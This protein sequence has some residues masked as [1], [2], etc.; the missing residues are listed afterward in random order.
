MGWEEYKEPFEENRK[1]E[2]QLWCRIRILQKVSASSGVV[3]DCTE[4]S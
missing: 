3:L 2:G 4:I 1:G